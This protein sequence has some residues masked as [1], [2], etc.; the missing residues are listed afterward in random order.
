MNSGYKVSAGL[1]LLVLAAALLLSCEDSAITAPSDGQ[2]IATANPATVVLDPDAGINSATSTIVAQVFDG[3]GFPVENV[4]VTFSSSGGLLASGTNT[5]VNASTCSI[6]GSPCTINADCVQAVAPRIVRTDVNGNAVDVLTVRSGDPDPVTVTAFSATLSQQV[7]VNQST[8]GLNEAPEAVLYAVPPGPTV[9][10]SG[11]GASC[12]SQAG[13]QVR[14]DGTLS[15]DDNQITCYKWFIDSGVAGKDKW[16]QG[17]LASAV[18][19]SFDVEQILDVFLLVSDDD[20]PTF[21]TPCQPPADNNTPATDCTASDSFFDA[22]DSVRYEIV[23]AND[24]P[25]VQVSDNQNVVL[26]GGTASVN[27]SG[28]ATDTETAQIDLAFS[29]DCRDGSGVQSGQTVTCTYTTAGTKTAT[30][31]VTDDGNPP[32]ECVQSTTADVTIVVSNPSP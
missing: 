22:I 14:F 1:A 2:I 20:N 24:P 10:C 31:R 11:G 16:Y 3:S 4:G 19:R 21:C 32:G 30:F 8:V 26:S 5:C 25:V 23:C 15:T 13:E 12:Q 18:S 27:L 17:P 9:D 29:W 28:S 6:T 7:E